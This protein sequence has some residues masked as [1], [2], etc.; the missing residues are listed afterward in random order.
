MRLSQ[1]QL[2]ILMGLLG[3]EHPGAIPVYIDRLPRQN[4]FESDRE[5]E[6]FCQNLERRGLV[7][8][9]NRW[10]ISLTEEGARVVT[11]NAK[12]NTAE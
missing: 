10:F 12:T 9:K 7:R 6:K 1:R 4:S 11:P 8:I 2:D 3:T 5:I